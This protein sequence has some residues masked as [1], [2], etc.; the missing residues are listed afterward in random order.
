[1]NLSLSFPAR[2]LVICVS[3]MHFKNAFEN[4]FISKY[5][6]NNNINHS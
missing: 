5:F 4:F 3:F 2:T 1:V 6:R